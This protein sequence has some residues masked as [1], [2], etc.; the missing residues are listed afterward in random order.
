MDPRLLSA[1]DLGADFQ[2]RPYHP[3][4]RGYGPCQLALPSEPVPV[5][6]VAAA[7]TS[8]SALQ[9]SSWS[10]PTPQLPRSPSPPR[11]TGRLVPERE[12]LNE[13]G[14][15]PH[16]TDVAGADEAFS[17]GFVNP[18]DAN[19][20]TVARVGDTLVVAYILFH[21]AAATSDGVTLQIS[22]PGDG[23]PG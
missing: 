9:S 21:F 2:D 3:D 1:A 14:R 15:T 7:F 22:P 6:R 11:K 16:P 20:V 13:E 10:M 19:G 12:N 23:G 18:N 4:D 5:E 17:I 8:Q